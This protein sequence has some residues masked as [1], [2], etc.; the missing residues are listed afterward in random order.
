MSN[1]SFTIDP[2]LASG[3]TLGDILELTGAEAH[4]AATVKRAVPGEQLDL[5]DGRG[6]RLTVSVLEVGR[7][8]LSVRV[9]QV[10]HE[11][12]PAI[13]ISLTQALAKSDRDLQ[14]VE[15]AVELGISQVQPWQ[16]ERSIVRW[17][18]A[19]AAKGQAKW[20]AQVR[21]AQKQSRRTHEPSVQPLCNSKQLEA[22]IA[23]HVAAGEL[24]IVLHEA[25][26]RALSEVVGQWLGAGSKYGAIRLIVGPEGGI[27]DAEI[28]RFTAAGAIPALL[29]QHVLRAST[30]G[31]AALV[32]IRHL[33][34]EL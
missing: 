9:E 8:L 20:Q 1:Q 29:G 13:P 32:L 26:Q 7:E 21:A 23:E 22:Q 27:S 17:N 4:H 24:V 10:E 25:E 5:L 16:A 19:K 11:P 12:A 30:A 2:E 18:E 15:A 3:A 31:P 6:T 14:A 28:E 34:G 33:L